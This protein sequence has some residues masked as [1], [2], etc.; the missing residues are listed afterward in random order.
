MYRI[1]DSRG[2]GK[3]SRLMLLAKEHDAAIVCKHPERMRE[4]AYSYGITGLRFIS[5]YEFAQDHND[6]AL[7]GQYVIDEIEE[8]IKLYF[9]K[10]GNLLGY[11]L[12]ED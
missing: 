3:T 6:N 4:K 1:I 12:T 5:Y 9:L 10:Q 8:F 2:T 11:T 7:I